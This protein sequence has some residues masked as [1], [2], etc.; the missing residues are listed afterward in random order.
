[1]VRASVS[2]STALEGMTNGLNNPSGTLTKFLKKTAPVVRQKIINSLPKDPLGNVEFT[3]D[4]QG[5]A[6]GATS[7][8]LKGLEDK[9][10]GQ[11]VVLNFTYN[12]INMP[13]VVLGSLKLL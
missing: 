6:T 13:N 11:S 10:D 12:G 2:G 1:M 5:L 7:G 8:I 3:K 4:F 9:I